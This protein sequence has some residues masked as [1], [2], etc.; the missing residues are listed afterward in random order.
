MA[1]LCCWA[2]SRY[3]TLPDYDTEDGKPDGV[4][5]L[6]SNGHHTAKPVLVTK[7]T[8]IAFP[9]SS[10]AVVD[11]TNPLVSNALVIKCVSSFAS[12]E[13]FMFVAGV[14]RHWR[15]AWNDE[16]RRTTSR[17]NAARSVSRLTW[18]KD[19]GLPWD[20][21]TAGYAAALGGLEELKY[22][23]SEGCPWNELTCNMAAAA[24]RLEVLR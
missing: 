6:A 1:C 12:A 15:A 16:G 13:G 4:Y 3:T 8:P 22:V 5:K 21:K 2:P 14:S 19:C 24:G 9:V 10:R 23:R 20:E 18:S 7:S 11:S 17:C